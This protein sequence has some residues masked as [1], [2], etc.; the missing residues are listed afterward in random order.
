[1]LSSATGDGLAAS[2]TA[3]AYLHALANRDWSGACVTRIQAEREEAARLAGSCERGIANLPST[4]ATQ[5]FTAGTVGAI[6]KRGSTIAVDIMVPGQP[7]PATTLFLRREDALWLL[8]DLPAAE[9][10]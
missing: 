7:R 3:A 1:V 2:G 8:V 6:R 9:A 4:Q 10:F 5:P